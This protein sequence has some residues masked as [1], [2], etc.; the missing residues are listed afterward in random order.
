MVGIAQWIWNPQTY[1]ALTPLF[2]G[3]TLV[4][5][6]IR[7]SYNDLVVLGVAL[8]GGHRA[9][10]AALPDPHGR[11]DAGIGRRSHADRMNGASSVRSARSAWIVGCILAAL[12]GILVAPTVTLSATALTLLIVDAYAA[13][14]IGRL[15]SIPMTFVGAHHP[16]AGGQLFRGL[17]APELV[18]SGLRGRRSRQSSCSLRCLMLP[19]SRLRGHRLLRSRELALVPSWRGTGY[20]AIGVIVGC[21]HVGDRRSRSP[22]S[23]A[24]TGSGGWHH[25]PVAGARS[26][27]TPAG[28]RY[29]R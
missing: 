15:R 18:R 13:S 25:R 14:V 4:I 29:A 10:P 27:A 12:A 7:I 20:F 17:P 19:Q 28:F 1:R 16:R 24:S 21:R 23:S 2:A 8:L 3:D 6:A 11:D 26:L 9:P 5:G 22:I